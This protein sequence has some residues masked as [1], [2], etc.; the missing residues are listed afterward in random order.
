MKGKILLKSFDFKIVLFAFN[1]N[2]SRSF[3][4]AGVFAFIVLL[5]I[6]IASLAIFTLQG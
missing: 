3:W 2:L 1:R 4:S 6:L 5:L